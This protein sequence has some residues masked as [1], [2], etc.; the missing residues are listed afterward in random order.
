[1]TVNDLDFLRRARA[2]ELKPIRAELVRLKQMPRHDWAET[3]DEYDRL[4]NA[5]DKVLEKYRKL[6]LLDD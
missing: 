3:M 6:G 5:Y 2:A 4:Q 1:M